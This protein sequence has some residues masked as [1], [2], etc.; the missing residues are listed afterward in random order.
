VVSPIGYGGWYLLQVVVFLQLPLLLVIGVALV[1]LFR[2]IFYKFRR[3]DV[4]ILACSLVYI[5]IGLPLVD[6]STHVR[7]SGFERLG[8]RSKPLVAA[9]HRFVEGKGRPPTDLRELVPSYLQE[10]PGTGMSAYPEFRY[11]TEP[12]QSDGNSWVVYVNCPYG[13][14]SFDMFMY[15]PLQNYPERGYS[16][17]LERVG[18]WAYVHE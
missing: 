16:G 7:M 15:F 12:N 17:V 6:A 9:V 14:L 8:L 5:L 4:R 13:G 2:V 1:T 3:G 10:V 18:E 11:S